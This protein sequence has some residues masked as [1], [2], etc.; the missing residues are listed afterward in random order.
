MIFRALD[1]DAS[2]RA[3]I[4]EQLPG[5][6]EMLDFVLGRPFATTIKMFNVAARERDGEVCLVPL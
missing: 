5:V 3:Q 2:L 1:F 4:A 6:K